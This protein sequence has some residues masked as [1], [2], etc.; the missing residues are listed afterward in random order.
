MIRAKE[1]LDEKQT[2]KNNRL[3]HKDRKPNAIIKPEVCKLIRENVIG[4]GMKTSEAMKAFKVSRRQV[5][6]IKGEDPN[7]VKTHK[8]RR[9]KFSNEMKTELLHQLDQ[10]SSTTLPKMVHFIQ[11]R[12]D[13]NFS[14]QAVSKLIHDMDIS[15]K[16]VINIP[17]SW[18][19]AYL[20]EKQAAFFN[21][22]GLDLGRKLVYVDEAGFDLH[23]A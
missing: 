4:N 22:C 10:Q 14:T 15:W 8:K 3:T 6:R 13:V 20:I 23:C 5:Q 21:H 1:K 7:L 2:Y 16:Q 19:K 9:S 18:N 11:E 12:F 17:A